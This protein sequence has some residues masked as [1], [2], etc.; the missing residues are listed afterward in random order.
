M[1]DGDATRPNGMAASIRSRPEANGFSTAS[2]FTHPGATEF[3][4][5]SRLP[6]STAA[7]ARASPQTQPA[8]A[9]D[10]DALQTQLRSDRHPSDCITT[11][12][13]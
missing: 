10:R 12:D 6:S 1:S 7:V 9:A 3:T 11:P 4:V 5:M 8:R 2:V 13:R